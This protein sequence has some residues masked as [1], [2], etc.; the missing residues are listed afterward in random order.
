MSQRQYVIQYKHQAG[1]ERCRT[2]PEVSHIKLK[3]VIFVNATEK[4]S[5]IYMIQI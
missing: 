1:Q 4:A 2:R 5:D 3:P